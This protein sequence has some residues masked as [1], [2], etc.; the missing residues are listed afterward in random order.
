MK[1]MNLFFPGTA[2]PV[3]V[4]YADDLEILKVEYPLAY[5]L[6][7]RHRA[8]VKTVWIDGR[9]IYLRNN[10]LLA[11]LRRWCEAF[12][13]WIP[14]DRLR[15]IAHAID[16]WVKVGIICAALYFFIEFALAFQSGNVERA[17]RG[18]H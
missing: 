2:K 18:G 12:E 7:M 11:R 9:L 10:S 5:H 8:E 15:R 14:S 1:D 16:C 3:I 6:I 13:A 4:E 17:L